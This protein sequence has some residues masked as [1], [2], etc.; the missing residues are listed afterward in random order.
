MSKSDVIG[1]L[2]QK[3]SKMKK[4]ELRDMYDT[5]MTIISD[6]LCHSKEIRLHGIGT[7]CVVSCSEKKYRNPKSGEIIV[8][9]KQ[10]RVR[11]RASKNLVEMVNFK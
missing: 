1:K 6:E 4:T 5:F 11:F 3:F 7:L 8:S 10:N 9:P 2:G